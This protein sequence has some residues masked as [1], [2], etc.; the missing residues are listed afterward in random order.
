[1][2]ELLDKNKD[3]MIGANTNGGYSHEAVK[4][5]TK[6]DGRMR[7]YHLHMQN[8]LIYYYLIESL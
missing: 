5:I 4:R 6:M 3:A 1:M 8:W 7:A 2:F